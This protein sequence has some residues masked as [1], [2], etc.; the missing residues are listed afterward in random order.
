VAGQRFSP[1]FQS[2]RPEIIAPALA[3]ILLSAV[4]LKF[5]RS[6]YTSEQTK[7]SFIAPVIVGSV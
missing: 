5:A 7:A 3:S 4:N 1:V 6:I 2:R